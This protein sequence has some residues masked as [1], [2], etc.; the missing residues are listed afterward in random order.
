MKLRLDP[1]SEELL[2]M[3][4]TVGALKERT[5]LFALAAEI[6]EAF[7]AELVLR[8]GKLSTERNKT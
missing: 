3:A 5:H 2:Q 6:N 4:R 7:S 8:A 1:A